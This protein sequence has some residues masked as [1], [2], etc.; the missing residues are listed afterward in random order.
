MTVKQTSDLSVM[1]MITDRIEQH[2]VQSSI[3]HNHYNFKKKK[4]QQ[5]HLGQTSLGGTMSSE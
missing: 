1:S 4:Q 2:L 5:I 3:Y